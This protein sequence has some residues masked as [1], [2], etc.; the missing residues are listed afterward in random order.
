MDRKFLSSNKI[1]LI[2]FF[3][4]LSFILAITT[5]IYEDKEKN[6][7]KA[8]HIKLEIDPNTLIAK[9][10]FVLDTSNGEA[11]FSKNS[12]DIQP[13]ASITKIMTALTALQLFGEEED[14]LATSEQT[15]DKETYMGTELISGETWKLSKLIE[16]MLIESSNEAAESIRAYANTKGIDFIN[17]M[18][19]NTRYF[20]IW[21]TRFINASGLDVNKAEAGAYSTTEDITF[22][23]KNA[24]QRYPKIFETT[25]FKS[26]NISSESG[27]AYH[28][29]NT[30]LALS[31]LRNIY[32]SKTG[33]TELAG[34]N[35]VFAI[36]TNSDK[37]IIVCL[38]AS[39][40]DGRFEDAKKITEEIY[41]KIK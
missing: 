23:F 27:T 22:L 24:L 35:L 25:Q 26:Y 37:I 15:Y 5:K 4:F 14:V 38:L 12:K 9:S 31:D 28:A 34:G 33:Y 40:F 19:K 16:Y 3:L 10:V 18:N 29:Q 13:I 2:T 17:E 8:P 39:T 30:N 1:L 21:D 11:V 41:K 32:A 7:N 36:K 6:F 20:G